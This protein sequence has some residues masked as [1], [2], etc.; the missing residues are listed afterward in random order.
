MK[1]KK[2]LA[3][4]LTLTM[5][6]SS[7]MTAN[8][9]MIVKNNMSALGAANTLNKNSSGIPK[10]SLQALA[11]QFKIEYTEE[12]LETLKKFFDADLYAKAYPD[13]AKVYGNDKEALW[14]HYVTY[15]L[16]EG[17]AQIHNNFN[18]FAYISAYPDLQNAFGDD[19][20]AYYMHYVNYGINENR[21]YTTIDAV[22]KDGMTVIGI[23][24]QTIA[25]PT[26]GNFTLGNEASSSESN[27]DVIVS[28]VPQLPAEPTT[29][30]SEP[31][32]PSSPTEPEKPA[33]GGSQEKPAECAHS[34]TGYESIG[35]GNHYIF[36]K[37]CSK[38]LSSEPCEIVDGMCVKCKWV[39]QEESH[40]YIYEIYIDADGKQNHK[41]ICSTC[42]ETIEGVCV[43]SEGSNVCDV[44]GHTETINVSEV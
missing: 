12:T 15:G 17:R 37:Q 6:L 7:T 8:A 34:E 43:F 31:E 26:V 9:A 35:D 36:C 23:N 24:G 40:Q 32:E 27:E 44:C 5:C 19:L 41:G 10:G 25:S 20:L 3:M 42:K 21:K 16:K 38:K 18:V 30:P 39:I 11:S 14:N 13:V 4:I 29:P 1:R 33:D 28:D 22:T 2:I